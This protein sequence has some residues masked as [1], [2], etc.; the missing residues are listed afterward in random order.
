MFSSVKRVPIAR[1]LRCSRVILRR[2]FGSEHSVRSRYLA[3]PLLPSPVTLLGLG[4]GLASLGYFAWQSQLIG[5]DANLKEDISASVEVDKAVSPFP[6]KLGPPEFPLTI[7]YTLLGFGVRSVT[8][9]NFKVY[10]LGLYVANEDL[11]LISKI[12]STNY[13][14]LA[15]V[16]TDNSKD[17]SENVEQALQDPVKSRALI[18][19]LIDGGVRM[20]AKITPIRNTDFNHLKEG[21]V[22]SILNHPDAKNNQEVVSR[23]IRELKDAFTR[24]G[25]VPKNDDLLIE[26]QANG[27][28]Q[29]SYRSRKSSESILLGRVDEPMIGRLL[30]SQYLSGPKPL[31]GAARESFVSKIKTLV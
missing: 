12:F 28:L 5:N 1:H 19:S 23:G 4:T 16:D 17:H 15:F 8:F 6:T 14:S 2:G 9:V 24:K 10:G 18:G 30:F 25:V 7:P 3:S 21:L 13:L 31:S 26:L 29:L 27:S 22:K 20:M 11:P